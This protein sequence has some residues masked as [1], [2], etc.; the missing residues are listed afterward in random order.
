MHRIFLRERIFLSMLDALGLRI[1]RFRFWITKA[2]L[3][4]PKIPLVMRRFFVFV[5]QECGLIL[6][7]GI[8]PW[9]P[10]WLSN[11]RIHIFGQAPDRRFHP[12]RSRR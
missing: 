10:A 5:H 11:K 6:E 4:I 2:V 1:K 12:T 3:R 9:L 7:C 8:L